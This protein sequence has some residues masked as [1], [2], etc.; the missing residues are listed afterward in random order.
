MEAGVCWLL[1]WRSV[2]C[3]LGVWWNVWEERVQGQGV[4][5]EVEERPEW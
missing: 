4:F 1:Q 5:W 2:P 3:V